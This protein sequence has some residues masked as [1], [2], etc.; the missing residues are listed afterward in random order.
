M[1][2]IQP[3][4]WGTSPLNPCFLFRETKSLSCW[5]LRVTW[6]LA[7]IYRTCPLSL[8]LGPG[9]P[10]TEKLQWRS[11]Q[12]LYQQLCTLNSRHHNTFFL[13]LLTDPFPNVAINRVTPSILSPLCL[14]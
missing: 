11:P 2:P 7:V 4:P 6:L 13:I 14:G 9:S 1:V 12:K 3:L 10:E 8:A 5:D